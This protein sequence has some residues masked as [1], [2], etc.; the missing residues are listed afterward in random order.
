[1]HWRYCSLAINHR[2]MSSSCFC[3]WKLYV[4]CT[5][6]Y[7]CIL[8]L[9]FLMKQNKAAVKTKFVYVYI[10]WI[11]WGHEQILK[12]WISNKRI[13]QMQ[14]LLAACREL[15][16]GCNRLSEVLYVFEHK[17]WYI[18]IHAPYTHIVILR[19]FSMIAIFVK[20]KTSSW[21]FQL[22][23]QYML[24][25]LL[26]AS[27]CD[28]AFIEPMHHNKPNITYLLIAGGGVCVYHI[29]AMIQFHVIIV[30]QI[31]YIPQNMVWNNFHCSRD[32]WDFCYEQFV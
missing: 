4:T 22:M 27:G 30:K 7:M 23:S 31:S 5:I 29:S 8:L 9:Y 32:T 1:M 12:A 17:T 16:R 25:W 11:V 18:F 19:H 24:S 6:I 3:L 28:M 21:L 14:V 13:S 10:V 20:Y 2:Y 15:A 26:I